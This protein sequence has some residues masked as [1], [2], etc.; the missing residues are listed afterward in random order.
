MYVIVIGCGKV[1][2]HVV[3]ALLASGQEAVAIEQ[4][5]R[6]CEQVREA[7]G[8][9]VIGG[10]G[11]EAA[12][13]AEAGTNRCDVL[14]AVTGL[15]ENNLA[16]CQMAKWKFNVPRTIALVN[17]PQN[18]VLFKALGVDVIVSSTDIILAH[19][20]EE[21]PAYSL[22][23]LMPMRES[24]R[25][26]VGIHIPRDAAVVGKTLDDLDLPP[27]SLISALI[28]KDGQLRLPNSDVTIQAEDQV[29]AITIPSSE[30]A[31]ATTLTQA[32]QS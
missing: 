12:V 26:L 5:S 10:D 7:L 25:E 16:A 17:D 15:D 19:I 20:E 1:G 30:E 13:L 32:N 14:I 27:N 4:D 21:L 3:T 31:L 2:Y 22:V 23:H 28:G 18:D 24:N 11:S 9:V 8:S 29:L 6:R